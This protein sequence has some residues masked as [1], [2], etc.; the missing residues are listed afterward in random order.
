LRVKDAGSYRQRAF[1]A[2]ITLGEPRNDSFTVQVNETW[3]RATT[4]EIL[5]RLQQALG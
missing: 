4:P 3:N 1:E 2:G 5:D